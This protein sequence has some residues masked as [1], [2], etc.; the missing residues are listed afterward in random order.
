M[1]W[2]SQAPA[3]LLAESECKAH[4]KVEEETE[5]ALESSSL[6]SKGWMQQDNGYWQYSQMYK[7]W[8][9]QVEVGSEKGKRST[10]GTS[11]TYLLCFNS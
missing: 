4:E 5:A 11:T 1:G 9:M 2:I 7:I 3:S 10:S 6:S 8:K